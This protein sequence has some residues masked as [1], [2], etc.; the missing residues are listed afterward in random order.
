MN[1]EPQFVPAGL[2]YRKVT[3]SLI[4][5]LTGPVLAFIRNIPLFT[6]VGFAARLK[7]I[8]P[9]HIKIM[10]SVE[11]PAESVLILKEN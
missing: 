9:P 10:L 8:D 11:A 6:T 5:N 3:T 4:D 1:V 2:V 7:K